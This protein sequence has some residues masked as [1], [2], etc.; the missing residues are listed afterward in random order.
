MSYV[1]DVPSAVAGTTV[2]VNDG[3]PP[4]KVFRLLIAVGSAV[5]Y[6]VDYTRDTQV[7]PVITRKISRPAI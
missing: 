7:P 3:W 6:S 2:M 4:R 5:E 1:P